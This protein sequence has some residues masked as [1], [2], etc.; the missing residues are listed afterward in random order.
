GGRVPW[1]MPIEIT[2]NTRQLIC[3]VSAYPLP[4]CRYFTP[5]SIAWLAPVCAIWP[6]DAFE[7]RNAQPSP[8]T[9][10][11]GVPAETETGCA[12]AH[13]VTLSEPSGSDAV[14]VE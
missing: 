6:G 11:S 5:Q 2:H 8:Y 4:G 7:P 13:T 3:A 12:M 1:L 14:T 10:A 9:V